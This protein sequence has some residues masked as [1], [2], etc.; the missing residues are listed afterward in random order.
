MLMYPERGKRRPYS[1]EQH[2]PLLTVVSR[3]EVDVNTEHC[4]QISTQNK[5]SVKTYRLALSNKFKEVCNYIHLH[6]V[7]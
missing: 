7:I 5:S 2:S 3:G 6:T 4:C 1:P